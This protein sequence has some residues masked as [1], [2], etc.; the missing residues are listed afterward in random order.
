MIVVIGDDRLHS[1]LTAHAMAQAATSK[2]PQVIKLG[3]SGGVI[4]RSAPSRQQVL[5]QT[6]AY[7]RTQCAGRREHVL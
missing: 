5:T 2:Q 6:Y 7:P 1:Q 4:T 3:K